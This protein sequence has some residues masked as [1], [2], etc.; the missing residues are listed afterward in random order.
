MTNMSQCSAVI[1]IYIVDYID[2]CFFVSCYCYTRRNI[3]YERS[4]PL[5]LVTK[6]TL[7]NPTM[8][9][10]VVKLNSNVLET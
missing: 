8:S 7:H 6:Y 10:E 3:E 5:Y 2:A 4:S 1:Q 9:E